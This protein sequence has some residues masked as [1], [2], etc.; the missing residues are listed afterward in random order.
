MPASVK[1]AFLLF[2]YVFGEAF[3]FL[4]RAQHRRRPFWVIRTVWIKLWF[5][6]KTSVRTERLSEMSAGIKLHC[7]E[8]GL[9]ADLNIAAFGFAGILRV[10]NKTV[11]EVSSYPAHGSEIEFTF[12]W[13]EFAGRDELIIH[14]Q[15]V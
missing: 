15:P 6:G 2:E 1:Q 7:R 5:Y 12:T 4:T 14:L 8:I 9:Q 3:E 11:I 10:Q 13:H